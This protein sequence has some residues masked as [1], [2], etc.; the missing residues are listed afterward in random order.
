[1]LEVRMCTFEMNEQ[2]RLGAVVGDRIYDANLARAAYLAAKK[3]ATD[4]YL[5]A[6]AEVPSEMVAFI[7]GGDG[8]LLVVRTA[9]AY[10]E[11]QGQ[12]TG[13]SGEKIRYALG[14]VKLRTPIPH[15]GK[16]V[17]MGRIYQ[18]H[19]EASG[20]ENLGEPVYFI[21]PNV[22]IVGPDEP[23]LL[24]KVYP[25]R[26]T[27]GTELTLIVGKR[28]KNT[29]PAEVYDHIWGY[30]ILNDVTLRGKPRTKNKMFNTS[31]PTGPWIVPKDQIKDPQNLRLQ[32]RLNGKTLQDGN[33]NLM[34]WDIPT[35]VAEIAKYMTLEPGDVI[36]TG[37]L[38]A[39]E[40]LSPGDVMECE[41]EGIGVL[42]NPVE[43]EG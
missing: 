42:R 11:E 31:G 25:A 1:M 15:P 17:C 41:V 35:C 5:L 27:F 16:L 24:P 4:P 13:P 2:R 36:A 39:T 33:T 38:G 21:K 32:F 9:L 8:S 30:T 3:I 26:T 20:L 37:D 12:D 34:M 23:V 10:L 18:G 6:N 29:P 43:L 19:L 40:L 7:Q 14:E 22:C 28:M